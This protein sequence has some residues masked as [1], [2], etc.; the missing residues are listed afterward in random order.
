MTGKPLLLVQGMHGLGDN[1][2][3]RA[4][5]R[6]LMES[7][8][9]VLETSW[10]CTYH[11]F[12]D[13]GLRLVRRPVALRTQLKNA[14]REARF[15]S[16]MKT[17]TLQN[18]PRMKIMY[19]V[20]HVRATKSNTILEAMFFS[21]GIGPRYKDADFRLPIKPAWHAAADA[22]IS[23]WRTTKPIMIYRPLVERPEWRGSMIRN[24]NPQ[25]YYALVESIRDRFFVVSVADLQQGCE[26]IAG[27]PSIKADV[28]FHRGELVFEA[29]A[30]LTSRASLVWTS[31]GFGSVL[32]PAVSTPTISIGGGYEP[33]IWHADSGKFSPYLGIDPIHPCECG[34]SQCR[35][36]CPKT[37]D[38]PR[39]RELI[40]PFLE[41]H[42]APR[43]LP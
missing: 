3:Q 19:G 31:S 17:I 16:E 7:R 23:T 15:F 8:D 26:W 20:N 24:A 29:L 27:G 22:I 30:A 38:V 13:Q 28:E 41:T 37:I 21:A 5:L 18:L 36:A 42:C 25:D 33:S 4:L 12:L 10:A 39:A 40:L 32:G 43:R 35:K 14:N 6:V 2:H 1:L 34:T 11:D 9:V